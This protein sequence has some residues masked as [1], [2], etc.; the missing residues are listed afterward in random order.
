MRQ[1]S[2]LRLPPQSALGTILAELAGSIMSALK[3]ERDLAI[4][5]LTGSDLW[6][7]L[8]VL[9]VPGLLVS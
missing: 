5:N 2:A 8:A 6:D 3:I 7:L 1:D 4:G 9:V